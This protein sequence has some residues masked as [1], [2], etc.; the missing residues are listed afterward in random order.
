MWLEYPGGICHPATPCRPFLSRP[1]PRLGASGHFS[2][3]LTPEIAHP[4]N[5]PSRPSL[6]ESKLMLL[7]AEPADEAVRSHR[8]ERFRAQ[9]GDDRPEFQ[10]MHLGEL[11]RATLICQGAAVSA[12]R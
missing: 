7:I 2:L 8:N 5:R 11:A 6:R 10:L 9:A 4:A 1:Q 12:G 3:H